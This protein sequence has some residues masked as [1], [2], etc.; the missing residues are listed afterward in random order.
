MRGGWTDLLIVNVRR[1]ATIRARVTAE[2]KKKIAKFAKA[3]KV[4]ESDVI[5]YA[6]LQAKVTTK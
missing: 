2:E 5:R 6:L 4:T 3:A 1:T